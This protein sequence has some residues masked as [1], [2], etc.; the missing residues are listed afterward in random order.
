MPIWNLKIHH[1]LDLNP[2]IEIHPRTTAF[3][4]VIISILKNETKKPQ[5]THANAP[6][7]TKITHDAIHAVNCPY[8][9]PNRKSIGRFRYVALVVIVYLSVQSFKKI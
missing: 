5:R 7:R 6:A 8:P 3:Y 4:V 1:L 9:V 2:R